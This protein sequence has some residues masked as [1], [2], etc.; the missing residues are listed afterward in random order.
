MR[1]SFFVERLGYLK[2]LGGVIDEALLRG[3]QV[4]ILYD[5]T[6]VS[7]YH[8]KIASPS[9]ANIPSFF[10]GTPELIPYKGMADLSDTVARCSD[11]FVVH[12]GYLM[13]WDDYIDDVNYIAYQFQ[14]VKNHSIPIVSLFSHFYDNCMMPLEMY[15]FFDKVCL[16]SEYSYDAHKEILLSICGLNGTALNEYEKE[17][18]ILMQEKSV[19]TGSALFDSFDALYKERIQGEGQDVILFVPKVDTHPYMQLVMREHPRLFSFLY[20]FLRYHGRYAT[21]VWKSPRYKEFLTRLYEISSNAGFK[22]VSKSRPKHGAMYEPLLKKISSEYID[23]VKDEYYPDYES[24]RIQ[25][26]ARLSIHMR[27]FSVLESVISGTPA[28][29]IQVP[30]VEKEDNPASQLL[31]YVDLVRSGKPDTMFNYPGCVHSVSWEDAMNVIDEDFFLGLKQDP[32][33]RAKYVDYYCGV[34]AITAAQR[35]VDV[36]E[37]ILR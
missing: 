30:I 8:K 14:Q 33:R 6:N 5:E 11:I 7:G 29:N 4:N 1:V 15:R 28:I 16:L 9:P 13:N 12:C 25:K 26:N 24:S 19:I 36:I 2:N 32:E 23:G 31:A 27:T 37:S 17:I 34:S 35:Q 10:N 18:E 22:I 3:H 20:S 21:K